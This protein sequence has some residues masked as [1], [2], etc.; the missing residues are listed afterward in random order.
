MK[1]RSNKSSEETPQFNQAVLFVTRLDTLEGMVDELIANNQIEIALDLVKR[2]IVRI[3]PLAKEKEVDTQKIDDALTSVNSLL[4]QGQAKLN[5]ERIKKEFFNLDQ[6]VWNLQH[7]LHLIM[8][9]KEFK[10]WQDEVKGD[11]E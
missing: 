7:K 8:P 1:F 10:A 9:H 6:E 4:N 3:M 11:F 2:V 5:P